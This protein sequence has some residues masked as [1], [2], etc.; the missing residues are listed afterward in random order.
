MGIVDGIKDTARKA[1]N[2]V[3]DTAEGIIGM[4]KSPKELAKRLVEHLNHQEYSKIAEILTL[5]WIICIINNLQC[6]QTFTVLP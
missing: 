1:T 3:V 4:P 5:V 2:S 6:S